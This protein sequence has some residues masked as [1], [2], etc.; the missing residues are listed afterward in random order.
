[1][2]NQGMV[3]ILRTL[4][5]KQIIAWNNLYHRILLLRYDNTKTTKKNYTQCQKSKPTFLM[6]TDNIRVTPQPS[7]TN[8]KTL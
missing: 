5:W 7:Y 8:V 4:C 3:V 6:T 2:A 1:V